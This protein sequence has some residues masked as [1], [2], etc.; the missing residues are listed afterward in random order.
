MCRTQNTQKSN[1]FNLNMDASSKIFFSLSVMPIISFINSRKPD[2]QLEITEQ[3]QNK[4]QRKLLLIK[5]KVHEKS[6][7]AISHQLFLSA[8]SR[9]R[10]LPA[11]RPSPARLSGVLLAFCSV[12]TGT[13]H[14]VTREC[15][16]LPIQSH[17]SA[18]QIH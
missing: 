4:C 3:D 5:I 2:L 10:S 7:P 11:G 12:A 8:S 6:V 17:Y 1:F 13:S 9:A 16:D 15:F 18:G 14:V